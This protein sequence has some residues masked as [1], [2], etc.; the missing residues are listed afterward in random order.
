MFRAPCL[1]MAALLLLP[2]ASSLAAVEKPAAALVAQ[3]RGIAKENCA[4]CHAI[5]ASDQSNDPKSP[6]FRELARKYPLS[7]LE[8][9]LA[10]GIMV[11]HQGLEMPR[12]QLSPAQIEALLAYM[13]SMQR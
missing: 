1:A 13:N 5:D 9:S 2:A 12:F 4:R 8:E 11:G 7:G 10:E 3:G 6:P